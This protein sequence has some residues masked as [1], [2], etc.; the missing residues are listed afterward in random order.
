MGAE[1]ASGAHAYSPCFMS[2]PDR[3]GLCQNSIPSFSGFLALNRLAMD[4]CCCTVEGLGVTGTAVGRMVR[5]VTLQSCHKAVSN[6]VRDYQ[7]AKLSLSASDSLPCW[8]RE[9]Y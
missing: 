8:S 7:G 4:C 6:V 5:A 2:H 9:P 3:S 1:H